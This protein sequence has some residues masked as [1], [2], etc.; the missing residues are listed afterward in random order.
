MTTQI[1]G[2]VMS[3]RKDRAGFKL[4]NDVWYTAYRGMGIPAELDRGD[5][6]S[7]GYTTK[8]NS[9]PGG[10]PYHNIQGSVTIKAAASPSEKITPANETEAFMVRKDFP[11]T[12]FAK[13]RAITRRHAFSAACEVSKLN[14]GVLSIDEIIEAAKRIEHYTAGDDIT[15]IVEKEMK[16]EGE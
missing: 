4:D 7:F 1:E 9:T 2:T 14:D 10:D 6:V 8:P 13:D 5:F 16:T 15:E 12:P 3:M 11:L